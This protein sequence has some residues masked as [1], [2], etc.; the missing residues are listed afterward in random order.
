MIHI[1]AKEY[2]WSKEE[3]DQIYPKE[4]LVLLKFIA[5]DK[6]DELLIKKVESVQQKITQLLIQH[7]DPKKLSNEFKDEL[8]RLVGNIEDKKE[9]NKETIDEELPDINKINEL[10]SFLATKKKR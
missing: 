1:F 2:G 7:G 9:S 8:M 5:H 3:I 10:K 4:S 6:K